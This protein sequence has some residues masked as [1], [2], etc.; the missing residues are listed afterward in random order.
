LHAAKQGVDAFRVSLNHQGIPGFDLGEPRQASQAAAVTNQAE[1][2]DIGLLSLIVK[3][4]DLTADDFR[5]LG[6]LK[7]GD[8]IGK[9]EQFCSGGI[10]LAVFRQQAPADER[11]IGDANRRA[12][13]PHRREIKHAVGRTQGVVAKLGDDNVGRRADQ[14]DH[15]AQY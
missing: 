1:N 15:A 3:F 14:R 7:F 6:Y 8:V 10:L 11:D 2:F 13:Q 4:V 5:A 12:G 9:I